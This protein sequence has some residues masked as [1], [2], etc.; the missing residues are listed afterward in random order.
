MAQVTNLLTLRIHKSNIFCSAFNISVINHH[1]YGTSA[2]LNRHRDRNNVIFS[3]IDI[4]PEE[5]GFGRRLWKGRIPLAVMAGSDVEWL[6]MLS[7]DSWL[8]AVEGTSRSR[9]L[10]FTEGAERRTCSDGARAS[11]SKV[12]SCL[13]TCRP[14]DRFPESGSGKVPIPLSNVLIWQQDSKAQENSV[15]GWSK[16]SKWLLKTVKG[17]T[18]IEGIF[19]ARFQ[20]KKNILCFVS[21]L[22]SI[23]CMLSTQR[24]YLTENN[25]I[26]FSGA[27]KPAHINTLRLA[28]CRLRM[29]QWIGGG[30]SGKW[31]QLFLNDL[32]WR[33]IE[34]C[35]SKCEF[36]KKMKTHEFP[37]VAGLSKLSWEL[38]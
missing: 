12:N 6:I 10:A 25:E 14:A 37:R 32:V 31:A 13:D 17:S 1:Y 21:M 23:I 2:N 16:R 4:L 27:M 29:W 33:P 22:L 38:G 18:G 9:V 28:C 36:L 15:M 30:C 3:V 34:R 7:T 8:V 11:V 24:I 20:G 26:P 35:S 19:K 5:S